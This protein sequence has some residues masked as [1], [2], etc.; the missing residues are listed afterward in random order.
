MGVGEGGRGEGG[1]PNET[2]R[3][4]ACCV[5]Q[6]RE[7]VGYEAMEGKAYIC[8]QSVGKKDVGKTSNGYRCKGGR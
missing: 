6:K 2:T 1:P 3:N 4:G 7:E 8:V 5:Y